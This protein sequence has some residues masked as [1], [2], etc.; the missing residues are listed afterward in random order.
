MTVKELRKICALRSLSDKR[1]GRR[2][3]KREI[4]RER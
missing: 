3:L 1:N 4:E 2:K